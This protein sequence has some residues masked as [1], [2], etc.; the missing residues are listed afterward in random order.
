MHMTYSYRVPAW[1]QRACSRMQS[2]QRIF[3]KSGW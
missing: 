2:L 1:Q 3:L